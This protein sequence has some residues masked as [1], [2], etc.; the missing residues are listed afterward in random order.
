MVVLIKFHGDKTT[1]CMGFSNRSKS[2]KFE[3][4]F[5]DAVEDTF[6]QIRQWEEWPY[7]VLNEILMEMGVKLE[8]LF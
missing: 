4:A 3:S 1:W 2:D 6:L 7:S 8:F 5:A